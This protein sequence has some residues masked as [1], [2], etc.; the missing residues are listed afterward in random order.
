MNSSAATPI[1]KPDWSTHSVRVKWL[2]DSKF[3]GKCSRMAAAIGFS[4]TIL[5]R[6]VAGSKPGPRLR[7][8]IAG[9]LGVHPEWLSSGEGNP[10]PRRGRRAECGIPATRILLPGPPLDH[11]NLITDGWIEVTAAAVSPSLYW[12]VLEHASP[13]VKLRGFLGGDRLLMETDVAK[14]PPQGDLFDH[15]CI[16]RDREGLPK[17]ATVMHHRASEENGEAHLM[18]EFIPTGPVE[19]A[20]VED[21]YRH[22]PDGAVKHRRRTLASDESR[23]GRSRRAH[24]VERVVTYAD[25]LAVWLSVIHRPG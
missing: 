21:I 15:I 23:E 25:F 17:L 3:G 6:V 10:F 11:Q 19:G 8:A 12:L 1:G 5:A 9:K 4:H 18:A 7:E 20:I 14:F 16:V 24:S 13:L 22:Y 2:I